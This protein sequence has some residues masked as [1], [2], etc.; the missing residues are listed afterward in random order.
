[1]S[2]GFTRTSNV[3]FIITYLYFGILA[4]LF[5]GVMSFIHSSFRPTK[6]SN[7]GVA[8]YHV[9]AAL[10]LYPLQGL[11]PSPVPA[12]AADAELE[13]ASNL[14]AASTEPVQPEPARKSPAPKKGKQT[15]AR[16]REPPVQYLMT[17]AQF[18]SYGYVGPGER[19]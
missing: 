3:S 7:P 5:A 14:T 1:M 16:V 13:P 10:E 12:A 4:A 18:H 15:A 9:P 2:R 8:A 17:P 11:S 19:R 6:L